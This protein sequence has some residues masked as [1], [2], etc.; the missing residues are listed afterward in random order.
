MTQTAESTVILRSENLL[1]EFKS[2][3]ETIAAVK[4]INIR[5]QRG[6]FT[7]LRGR[8]GSG[9]TTLINLLGAMDSPTSGSVWFGG[10]DITRL[11]E[12]GRDRL[13]RIHMGF[14]FQSGGL[15]SYMSAYENVEFGL[16]IA[17]FNAKERRARA[18]ECLSLVGLGKRM[19]HRP[20]E[21]SGGEQQ[22]VAIARAIA[23]KPEIVFADEPTSALDTVMG[24]QVVR[25]FKELIEKEGITIVMTTHDPSM[26]EVADDV[27]TLQDGE[28]VDGQ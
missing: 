26:I 21:M 12:A 8:S 20:S 16:R 23:H 18:E 25:V 6:R 15:M 22:R 19:Y 17:G 28:T 10:Q 5:I 14:V 27:I 7:I 3:S 11:S 24:L 13:R 2:G 4:N 9:K 1:R